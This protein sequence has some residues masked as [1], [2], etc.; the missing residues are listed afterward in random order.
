MPIDDT[1]IVDGVAD[2]MRDQKKC[3]HRFGHISYWDTSKVTNMNT[4]FEVTAF[5]DNIDRWDVSNV[6]S[7]KGM[8]LEAYKFNQ[9]LNS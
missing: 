9:P 3:T 1:T 8:F 5:N 2:W 6:K 4:L 7:M